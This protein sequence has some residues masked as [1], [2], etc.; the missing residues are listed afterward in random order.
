MHEKS[1][2]RKEKGTYA[3]GE[4]CATQLL[5]EIL[6]GKAIPRLTLKISYDDNSPS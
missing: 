3:R 5:T 4:K 1:G 2:M 6:V